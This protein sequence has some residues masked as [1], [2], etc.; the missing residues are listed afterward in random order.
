MKDRKEHANHRMW[1]QTLNYS[2]F[3]TMPLTFQAALLLL[4]FPLRCLHE[5]SAKRGRTLIRSGILF[6]I[7][8]SPLL[9]VVIIT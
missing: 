4:S 9:A 2:L 3:I 8:W 1:S 6:S 5:A 7:L